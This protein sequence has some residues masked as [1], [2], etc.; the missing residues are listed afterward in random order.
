MKESDLIGKKVKLIFQDLNK[1]LIKIGVVKEI[2]NDFVT[3]KTDK[4]TEIIPNSRVL[5]MEI[6]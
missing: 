2:S 1:T 3:I 6:I 4:K 5:R